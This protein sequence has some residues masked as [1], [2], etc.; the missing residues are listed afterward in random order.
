MKTK[1]FEIEVV[2]TKRVRVVLPEW[3]AQAEAQEDWETG[4]WMLEG[5][6]CEEKM[7][8]IAK[9]AARMAANFSGGYSHDGVG[10][11][12]ESP[13]ERPDYGKNRYQVIAIVTDDEDEQEVVAQSDWASA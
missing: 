3:Y 6:S 4:L 8:D 10:V 7:A 12:I 5:D 2:T 1:T 13:F 9:Y 11:M